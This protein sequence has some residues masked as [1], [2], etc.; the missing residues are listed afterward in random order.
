MGGRLSGGPETGNQAA[1]SRALG[2]RERKVRSRVKELPR[3][4][5]EELCLFC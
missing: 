1:L 5:L 4:T 3:Q 2:V